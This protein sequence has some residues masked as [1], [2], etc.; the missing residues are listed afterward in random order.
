MATGV[1]VVASRLAGIPE[2]VDDEVTGLLTPPGDPVALAGAL[3]RL[4]RDPAK[5]ARFGRSGRRQVEQQFDL[6]A[7]GAA[8]ASRFP[9][10][11]DA[12][13]HA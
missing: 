2:L 3:E 13:G 11:S 10:P 9:A 7:N 1:P 6:W 8:L 12:A 4:W 5:R